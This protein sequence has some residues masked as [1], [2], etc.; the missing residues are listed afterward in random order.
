MKKALIIAG[1]ASADLYASNIVRL[2]KKRVDS[3]NF[4]AIGGDKLREEN[5]EIILDYKDISVVGAVEVFSHLTKIL[6]AI[7]E[8]VKWIKV[9]NPDFVIFIDFPDFNFRVIRKIKKFYTG[10]IIY[11]ISPQV[12]AWR[13]GRAKFIKKFV[14]LMIVILPF[15]KDFYRNYNFHVEYLGHPLIDIVKP[16]MDKNE[17][18]KRFGFSEN[19]KIVSIFPGSRKKEIDSHKKIL[20]DFIEMVKIKYAD[21]EFAVVSPNRFI[22]EL[23]SS[24]FAMKRV[25]IVEGLNYDAIYNSFIVIAKS[26][27]TTLETA[28]MEKPAI[29]FYSVNKISYLLGKVLINVPYISLPN[30]ILKELVY[31]EFIQKDFNKNNLFFAFERFIIDTDLYIETVDKLRKLKNLLGGEQFFERFAEKIVEYVYG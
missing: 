15:E 5:I 10:K 4:F 18:R 14:D 28:I 3:I 24:Y 8:T 2:V 21:I 16:T 31:P 1:E 17:F 30:L 27:T 20:R 7:K 23:I 6:K 19:T 11:F 22:T 9:N 25:K 26:G 13:Q 29:V 12:W